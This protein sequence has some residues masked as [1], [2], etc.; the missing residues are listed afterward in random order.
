MRQPLEIPA[1]AAEEVERLAEPI[2][3]V[4]FAAWRDNGRLA[5]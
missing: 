1:P 2:C 5:P 3:P 4:A